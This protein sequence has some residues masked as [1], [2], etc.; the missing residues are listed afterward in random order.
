[1]AKLSLSAHLIKLRQENRALN[2]PGD[3]TWELFEI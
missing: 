1:M 2:H 3:D